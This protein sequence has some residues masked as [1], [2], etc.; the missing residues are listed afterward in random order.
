MRTPRPLWLLHTS[1]Q[2]VEYAHELQVKFGLDIRLLLPVKTTPASALTVCD[3]KASDFKP[4]LADIAL[5]ELLVTGNAPKEMAET[6]GITV[7]A[8]R[9]RS[10]ALREKLGVKSNEAMVAQ[11]LRQGLIK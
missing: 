10:Q 4:T 9:L 2:S 1:P 3:A 7:R 6:L 8:V 5:L 11:A